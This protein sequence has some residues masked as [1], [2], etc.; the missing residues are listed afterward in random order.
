MAGK[1]GAIAGGLP[2]DV[3]LFKRL[4]GPLLL[5]LL[6]LF[7]QMGALAHG[8]SHVPDQAGGDEPV[9][10]LCL[11]YAPLG[12]AAAVGKLPPGSAPLVFLPATA[13]VVAVSPRGFRAIY[14][15]RAPPLTC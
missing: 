11:A 10:E 6:F 15:S 1:T 14:R 5:V 2:S 4:R 7:A 13:V 9:C 3:A 8:F 12:A